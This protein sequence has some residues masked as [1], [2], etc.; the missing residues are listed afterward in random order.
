MNGA[1]VRYKLLE[2]GLEE[3]LV[4]WVR[5]IL[6]AVPQKLMCGTYRRSGDSVQV[7]K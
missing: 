3:V 6:M 4:I 2:D 1:Y 7:R 5:V